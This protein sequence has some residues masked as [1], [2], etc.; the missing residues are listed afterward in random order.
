MQR[1]G[2]DKKKKML[3]VLD[4][5]YPV[6]NAV[7]ACI[8]NI[9]PPFSE[10]YD[11]T[12][13]CVRSDLDS[14]DEE[15]RYGAVIKRVL[16]FWDYPAM[17]GNQL[18]DRIKAQDA[19]NRF[20]RSILSMVVKTVFYPFRLLAKRYGIYNMAGYSRKFGSL[21]ED[22]IRESDVVLTTVMPN[23]NAETLCPVLNKY[24]QIK[25]VIIQSDPYV[26]YAE[27]AESI[28]SKEE[29]Q[30]EWYDR[31]TLIVAQETIIDNIYRAS[32]AYKD[33]ILPLFIPSMPAIITEDSQLEYREKVTLDHLNS[34][35][36]GNPRRISCVFTGLFYAGVREPFFLMDL[37]TGLHELDS[38][39]E[40]Y[41]LGMVFDT[42]ISEFIK[43][44][45]D[46]FFYCGRQPQAICDRAQH[47]ADFLI[48]VGNMI[49][50][51]VP[52]KVMQYISTRKPLINLYHM[53]NDVVENYLADY[54]IELSLYYDDYKSG[55]DRNLNSIDPLSRFIDTNTGRMADY[56]LIIDRYDKYSAANYVKTILE[57]KTMSS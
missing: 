56:N 2:L 9:I 34:T 21:I 8:D 30:N 52:S 17:F 36:K 7:T 40:V 43:D 45:S 16:T 47:E 13:V 54:P 33:K 24:P 42:D 51:L 4:R 31:A 35:N 25:W 46:W 29:K 20:L 5:Y 55:D 48:N 44:N 22:E 50:N 27:N 11:I 28:K 26:D 39:I 32:S 23:E 41:I 3:I 37:F 19:C 10:N 49:P 18:A 6:C 57:H 38:A 14:L 53:R 12:L 15:I 1:N